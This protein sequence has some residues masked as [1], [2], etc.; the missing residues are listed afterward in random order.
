MKFRSSDTLIYLLSILFLIFF[1]YFSIKFL[2]KKPLEII[3]F[4]DSDIHEDFEVEITNNLNDINSYLKEYLF[5]E[6]YLFQRKDNEIDIYIN[7][8]K[9]FAKNNSTREV[10][11]YLSL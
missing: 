5:I 11:F 6:S 8:N 1:V 10:I 7:L 2:E 4:L 9:T 3:N